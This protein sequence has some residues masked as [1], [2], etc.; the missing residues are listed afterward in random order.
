MPDGPR[1]TV[2]LTERLRASAGDTSAWLISLSLHFLFLIAISLLTIRSTHVVPA[3]ILTSVP[4][5][6]L[7]I[8]ELIPE[9]FHFDPTPREEIGASAMGGLDDDV[10]GQP[11][12][13]DDIAVPTLELD[14]QDIGQIE[15]R[16][17]VEATSGPE[18]DL[19]HAV[20][21]AAGVGVM[22]AEGAIDRITQEI[23]LSLEERMTLV[24]WFFDRSGSLQTQRTEV[25]RH[26]NRIYEELGVVQ[27]RGDRHFARH[28]DK[29][30]LTSVVAFGADTQFLIDQPT[31]DVPSIRRAVDSITQDDSGIERVFTAINAAAMRYKKYRTALDRN[32]MFVAFTDEAGDDQERLDP[33][34]DL[35]RRL[36]IP[37]YVV[38]VPA[39]FGRRE[40]LVKWVDPDPSFDQTPQWGR[41]D[42]GPE[43]LLPERIRIALSDFREDQSP[44]DSGFGPF[45]LTRLCYETGGIYFTVHPNRR[46]NRRVS[47]AE[48]ARYSAYFSAFFDPVR[49]R[50]YQPEYVSAQQYRRNVL[51]SR[52]RSAL[53]QAAE[54]SWLQPLESPRRRFVVL[55]EAQL[56]NDLTDAQKDAARI[57]PTLRQLCEIL[58][59]GEEDRPREIVA[60][61]Q[62][63]FDLAMGRV[64][65]NKVR[66]EGYNLM[67][68]RPN[69]GSNLRTRNITRGY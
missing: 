32:V 17:F 5:E 50:R 31:D 44:I 54:M 67:L 66:A 58:R 18:A 62:A 4:P 46:V 9:A 7:Q 23:L 51:A 8:K 40:T 55:S 42:Q 36:A 2:D 48:T 38:G 34:V 59:A 1:L 56:A 20:K 19:N 33:T 3:L 65:A 25:N 29:P 24:V 6:D 68:R 27:T 63:G 37:V 47:R 16:Q 21:G 64:L 11:I 69:E 13:S 15:A 45:A 49:M 35:C 14:V 52:L 22:G 57:E 53:V 41:V 60:R 43:S 28:Q 10:A 39:P 61:W 30:L 12:V 26:F